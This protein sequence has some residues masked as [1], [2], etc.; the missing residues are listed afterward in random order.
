[1][2]ER[3]MRQMNL[4]FRFILELVVLVALLSWGFNSSDQLH[5]QLILGLG[6]A[7]MGMAL[8]ATFVSPKAPRRLEDP[9]RVALEVV[10]FGS[11][12]LAFVASGRLILG[13]LLA[14]SAAISLLLMFA[15]DQRGL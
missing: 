15:W 4:A 13:L 1:M 10:V 14:V 3:S 7:A 6:A 8:W 12:V 2:S 5:V 9:T 11:G